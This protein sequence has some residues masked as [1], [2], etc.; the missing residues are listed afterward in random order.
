MTILV[1]HYDPNGDFAWCEV[2]WSWTLG[3]NIAVAGALTRAFDL[4]ELHGKRHQREG[5]F[6]AFDLGELYGKGFV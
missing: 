5:G 2:S 1:D 3:H 4:G 6:W